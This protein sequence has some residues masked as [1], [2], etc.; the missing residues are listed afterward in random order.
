MRLSVAGPN[1]EMLLN[2]RAATHLSEQQQ[3]IWRTTD[4]LFAALLV[5][6][7]VGAMAAAIWIS[8]WTWIGSTSSVNMHVWIA[9]VLG[10]G[11]I[12]L[13]VYLARY[14][15]GRTLTRHVIAIAQMLMGALLIHLT[16]GRIETHFHVFGSL[17]FLAFYRDWRV[18]VTATVVVALDHLLRGLLWPE[19][20]FGT[21]NAG[22]WRW[23]EH[24]GW[25]VFED[26]ILVL[27]CLRGR[28]EMTDIARRQAELELTHDRIELTVQDRTKS[29]HEAQQRFTSAFDNAAIGMALVSSDGRWL[30]VNRSLCEIVG[31]LPADLLSSTFQ[32]I[33]HPEDLEKDLSFVAQMVEGTIRTYQMEKR[34]LHKQGH[35]V[36]VLL[37]VSLVRD[38]QEQPLYF[39][40]QVEDIAQ[41]KLAERELVRSREA[42]ESANRSK[43]EFLANM[44]HEI[45]TPMNGIIGMTELALDTD[46]NV[47][48]RDYV[49]TVRTSAHV[50]LTIINDILDFSKIEAGKLDLDQVD[51]PLR[52]TMGSTIKTLAQRAH[53]KGLEL[54][55]QVGPDV[56]DALIGD[57]IRLRQV[58]VNLVGNSLK[59]TEK[60]EVVVQVTLVS[61]DSKEAIVRF[62][63]RDT[64]I[65][66]P[67][68][69]QGVIFDAFSQADGSTTRKYGGTGLGLSISAQLVRMMNGQIGVDSV[70][71]EGSTFHFT[72]RFALGQEIPAMQDRPPVLEDMPVLIVDDN[73]PNRRI[74][75]DTLK[76]WNMRPVA[77]ESGELGFKA[78]R[79]ASAKGKPYRMV[80]L[81]V[82]MPDMDGYEV[83]KQLQANPDFGRPAVLLLTSAYQRG[84]GVRG[85][86]L[87]VAACLI[88][89][90]EPEEL[91]DNMLHALNLSNHMQRLSG[92]ELEQV[93]AP[94]TQGWKV[95]LA[96]DN[97]INQKVA[98]G[99]LSKLG[100]T[101]LL[102]SD[103]KQALE[104]LAEQSVDLILMDVQMPILDGFET[105]GIIREREKKNGGHLPIVAMTAHAMKGDRERCLDAG[106]D[107]Y[108]TKPVR[109]E[110]LQRVMGEVMKEFA[111]SEVVKTTVVEDPGVEIF[112]RKL[113]LDQMGGDAQ[114]L[115]EI[116]EMFVKDSTDYLQNLRDA[117]QN[118]DTQGMSRS[119]HTLK[120]AL[121]YLGARRAQS[122]AQALE[123]MAHSDPENAELWR[124][125][126]A[127]MEA[128]HELLPIV[129]A[130]VGLPLAEL[131][132]EDR[133]ALSPVG[134]VGGR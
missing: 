94:N 79:E 128:V 78:L 65:G 129:R 47:I 55:W 59:F 24:A 4:R 52:T 22:N 73:E 123:T 9:I 90:V 115:D 17:A 13:P 101:I 114:L 6:Q 118:G 23:L 122:A 120:G 86:S 14:Q 107:N 16:G 85:Q 45:R 57:P 113:A 95:L 12:S 37:S 92:V 81:D 130:F 56:P 11:I 54:A 98:I 77:V 42:A 97:A 74:L 76:H 93:I 61:S 108:L 109:S 134:K 111:A 1:D 41:R 82:C 105:T 18:L 33:T 89:P 87:G 53:E 20:V 46:L 10:F 38:S 62:A 100:H 48:Q 117:A 119:A 127:V 19:S 84:D 32:A 121:G 40:A 26:I 91:Y 60:G 69:K 125:H 99:I 132:G 96:E 8:P 116:A 66:I 29:L 106:M 3:R 67:K 25:V 36:W 104:I 39:I 34:Y 27:A 64:G 5:F 44:S 15:P 80:L 63:I 102:A 58:L 21:S 43:S 124:T 28:K 126:E 71:G 75:H 133:F 72:A 83:A 35:Y 103:G 88:K 30:Q 110:E 131:G 70:M 31:Y 2:Q 50:L 51:F 68:D 7:W 112:D 49:Q